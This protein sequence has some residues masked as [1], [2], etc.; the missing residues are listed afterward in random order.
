MAK[1]NKTRT[2]AAAKIEM[3]AR[4]REL[5]AVIAHGD[6]SAVRLPSV[7]LQLDATQRC[8]R[9]SCTYE[10]VRYDDGEPTLDDLEQEVESLREDIERADVARV[11][12]KKAER[13]YRAYNY[14]VNRSKIRE[15][16]SDLDA[17]EY[18]L[19][20]WQGRIWA[21][22]TDTDKDIDERIQEKE[23]LQCEYNCALDTVNKLR[24]QLA[25][26]L[27]TKYM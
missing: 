5:R 1:C 10:S 22:D 13:F 15:L 4:V 18:W 27:N 8:F 24:R 3:D 2:L 11:E 12:L 21:I 26:V 9:S 14:V 25:D 23:Y 20:Q 6:A 17:A 7:V 19:A 16:K